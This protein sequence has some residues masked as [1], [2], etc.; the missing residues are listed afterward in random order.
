MAW[1]ERAGTRLALAVGERKMSARGWER[2][3]RVAVT[4]ADL[5]ES[6]WSCRRTSTRRSASGA[7]IERRSHR[8]PRRQAPVGVRRAQPG[9]SLPAPGR[10][11]A[12]GNAAARRGPLRV[13]LGTGRRH[14]RGRQGSPP[15]ARRARR[16]RAVPQSH[17]LSTYARLGPRPPG[18]AVRARGSAGW[19]GC[20]GG[21]YPAVHRLRSPAR[22]R[23]RRGDRR[24]RVGAGLRVGVGHR[25]GGPHRNRHRRGRRDRRARVRHRHRLPTG[26]PGPGGPSDRRR[27]RGGHRISPRRCPRAV[28]G[29]RRA[30]G[31]SAVS[32]RRWWWS[33]PGS[34]EARWITAGY[35]L[36]HGIPIFAVPGDVRRESSRGCNLLIRDGAHPVLDPDDLVEELSL[37]LGPPVGVASNLGGAPA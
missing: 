15:A 17:R 29:P 34:P 28:A 37:V 18:C 24:R 14:G 23:V 31:S 26:A 5:A 16:R 13:R 1:D 9:A 4:V 10:P 12:G 2:V 35:A 30:T 21:G 22:H 27:G 8:G 25:R 6:R 33:R 20:G 3:R 7:P 11:R 32:A 36:A 19:P